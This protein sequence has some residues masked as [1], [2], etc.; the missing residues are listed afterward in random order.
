MDVYCDDELLVPGKEE[1]L[2]YVAEIVD[3]A[4]NA[5]Y[6]MDAFVKQDTQKIY[7]NED[8]KKTAFNPDS[9]GSDSVSSE[10]ILEL[11]KTSYSADLRD[12]DKTFAYLDGW[13]WN[14]GEYAQLKVV[15]NGSR[16]DLSVAMSDVPT[17]DGV[18]GA[19]DNTAVILSL[20]QSESITIWDKEI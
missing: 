6:T 18:D 4:T 20:E 2:C 12:G 17:S 7:T 10:A 15:S 5:R 8:E 9:T 3:P 13:D 11:E 1:A 14:Y 16:V 19:P